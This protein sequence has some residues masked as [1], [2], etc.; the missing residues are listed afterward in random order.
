MN[1]TLI[2]E[3]P[4]RTC[5]LNSSS[6]RSLVLSSRTMTKADIPGLAELW[7]AS[8]PPELVQAVTHDEVL[9]DWTAAFD[10]EY[11]KL[12]TGSSLV[13]ERDGLIIAAIQT[14][15][16]AVWDETPAGPFIIE[17]IVRPECRRTGIGGALLAEALG[18]LSKACYRSAALRVEKD[19]VPAQH[20]YRQ[21]GFA[22]WAAGY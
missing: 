7:C 10:D 6:S 2:V 16:D 14:V 13:V 3:L 21:M 17:L 19:N 9:E 5:A 11:G 20:L 18:H 15:V 8:Y 22:D 1:D 4:L 12:E